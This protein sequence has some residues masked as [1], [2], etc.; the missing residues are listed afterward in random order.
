[1]LPQV[2]TPG[3]GLGLGGEML[4]GGGD[5]EDLGDLVVILVVL[6]EKPI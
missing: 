4:V 2:I 3:G 6:V 5:L 1:M